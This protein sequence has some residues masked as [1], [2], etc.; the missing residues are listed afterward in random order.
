[1]SKYNP[2][3]DEMNNVGHNFKYHPPKDDQ[4]ERY[5][6]LRNMAQQ[7]AYE[8]MLNAPKS[9]E[10]SLALTN[11]EQSIMWVNAAIARNE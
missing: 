9:R 11:L 7:L 8:Y 3:D 5:N 2:T 10:L 6:K 1:M 4:P